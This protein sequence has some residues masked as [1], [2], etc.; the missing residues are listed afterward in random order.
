MMS[1]E[2]GGDILFIYTLADRLHKT[3]D[4]ILR[5]SIHEREGWIAYFNHLNDLA[6]LNGSKRHI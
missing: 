4:E 5:I 3:V 6:K 1:R 2:G